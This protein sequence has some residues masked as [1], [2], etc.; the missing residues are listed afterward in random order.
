MSEMISRLLRRFGQD[1]KAVAAVEFALILPFLLALY[2]GSMEAAAL[3]TADKRVNTISATLGDLIGQWDPSV[4]KDLDDVSST[5]TLATYFAASKGIIAPYPTAGVKQVISLIFVN[6]DGT[7]KVIWSK[8]N[9]GATARKVGDPYAPLDTTSMTDQVA[10]GGCIIAAEASYSYKPIL[11][12]VFTTALNL[13]HT[14]Y[15]IPRYGATAV[16]NLTSL[17]NAGK[18][19]T[20]TA[21]TTGS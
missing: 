17:T 16:I 14:N 1:D 3:F 4:D 7:T 10:R 2:F 19:L 12:Q 8:A 5:G 15:F 20:S 13:S 18:A 6:T 9:G 11:G 21:C